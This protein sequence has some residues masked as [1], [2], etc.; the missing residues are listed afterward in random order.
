MATDE[1][2]VEMPNEDQPFAVTGED[3]T[4]TTANSSNTTDKE[5]TVAVVIDQTTTDETNIK[6]I[7]ASEHSTDTPSAVEESAMTTDEDNASFV[8]SE[9]I[10]LS[11]D[12]D[13]MDFKSWPENLDSYVELCNTIDTTQYRDTKWYRYIQSLSI[14][15]SISYII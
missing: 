12:I 9:P 13:S 1:Q 14:V 6:T 2:V 10:T 15:V 8:E 4:M 5:E 7:V 3:V 11:K